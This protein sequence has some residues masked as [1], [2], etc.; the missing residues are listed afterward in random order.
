M[1][2]E[3]TEIGYSLLNLASPLVVNMVRFLELFFPQCQYSNK[4][5][6]SVIEPE[7]LQPRRDIPS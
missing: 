2:T 5:W 7:K 3:Q 6:I 1:N 4:R